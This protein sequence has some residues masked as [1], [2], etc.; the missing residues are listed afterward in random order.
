MHDR[1]FRAAKFRGEIRPNGEANIVCLVA[2]G[3]MLAE[4]LLSS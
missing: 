4:N 1:F 3:A 2:G